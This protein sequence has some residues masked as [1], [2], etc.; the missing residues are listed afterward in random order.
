MTAVVIEASV[1]DGRVRKQTRREDAT[2]EKRRE[3]KRSIMDKP[4]R[5]VARERFSYIR[6]YVSY[7][8]N[9]IFYF[10]LFIQFIMLSYHTYD[11]M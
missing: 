11:A 4:M 3:E 8:I 1:S 2:E 6:S 10:I 9:Y 7:V 5:C